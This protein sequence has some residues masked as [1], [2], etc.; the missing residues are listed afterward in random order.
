VFVLILSGLIAIAPASGAE[1]EGEGN[2]TKIEIESVSWD[3]A[4]QGFVVALSLKFGL[5]T[6]GEHADFSVATSL[7]FD[8]DG[9]SVT[10]SAEST[11]VK[12]EDAIKDSENMIQ[13]DP[14][15]IPW[16]RNGGTYEGPLEVMAEAHIQNYD[17]LGVIL[18]RGILATVVVFEFPP[19]R[20]II[21]GIVT[22][23]ETGDPLDLVDVSVS[24]DG[25][26]VDSGQTNV[27][28]FYAFKLLEGTYSFK[29]EKE[30]FSTKIVAGVIILYTRITR[31]D[32]EL[33]FVGQPP[34][35]PTD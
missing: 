34:P 33:D 8:A 10:L 17:V 12:A 26:F 14:T 28:G 5:A 19:D 7:K 2:D 21:E 22:N 35:S 11:I 31:V 24:R 25:I 16:D 20:G 30:G 4:N 27:A 1:S 6:A 9:N 32:V 29:F 3:K 15:F 23:S 13:I 18:V